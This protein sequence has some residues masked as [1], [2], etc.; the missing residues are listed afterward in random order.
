MPK[1][2]HGWVMAFAIAAVPVVAH[3]D[4]AAS[5]VRIRIA[6]GAQ[7]GRDVSGVILADGKVATSA[8]AIDKATV[9]NVQVFK[10][11]A[12]FKPS[13]I[14][15][16][17]ADVA[18]L[19]VP[20]VSGGDLRQAATT[21]SASEKGLTHL[22][23]GSPSPAPVATPAAAQPSMTLGGA[24]LNACNELVG[25]IIP[26]QAG[27]A[28]SGALRV[29][30]SQPLPPDALRQ[31]AAPCAKPADAGPQ[32]AVLQPGEDSRKALEDVMAAADLRAQQAA[33]A[34]KKANA[35]N[36]KALQRAYDDAAADRL[37]A[38][39]ELE[40]VRTELSKLADE[41]LRKSQESDSRA[42][43]NAALAEEA[44]RQADV[45]KKLADQRTRNLLY[46]SGA[47]ALVLLLVG[48]AA[49][50]FLSRAKKKSDVLERDYNAMAASNRARASAP[51]MVLVGDAG[52]VKLQG[53]LLADSNR[54]AVIGR[55]QNEAD[56]IVE[57]EL[58][59]RRHAR[60]FYRDGAVMVEDL[61]ST[62]GTV[63]NGRRLS[64]GEVV[65]VREGD[66][67]ELA[68]RKYTLRRP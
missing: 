19:L 27:A 41:T 58:I 30:T 26:E 68:N 10:G 28:T 34:L 7:G 20:G 52:R 48:G 35:E 61:R 17:S 3:A 50:F 31:A 51:D 42:A 59:S 62:N 46:F 22:W 64:S 6:E 47:A 25:L 14:S 1:G 4:P 33:D 43:E 45:A 49:A 67:I 2:L 29:K 11:D 66:A 55:G 9:A 18:L 5:I 36:R 37:K 54:G 53:A 13:E 32:A 63:V 16:L 65:E 39:Q 40:A 38:Q 60:F 15:P 57:G 12:A 44:A 21:E 24:V 23:A 8:A 56:E